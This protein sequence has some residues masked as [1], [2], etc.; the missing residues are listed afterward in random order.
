MKMNS[1]KVI[2]RRRRG[3][4]EKNRWDEPNWSTLYA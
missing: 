1:V 2:L 3:R 4:R